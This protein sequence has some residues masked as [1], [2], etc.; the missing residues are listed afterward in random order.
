MSEVPK[1]KVPTPRRVSVSA[2]SE[3]PQRP[4]EPYQHE[5]PTP[6]RRDTFPIVMGGIIGALVI[7]LMVVVFLLSSNNGRTTTTQPGAGA[8]SAANSAAPTANTATL[9]PERIAMD[10]FKA[11]YDDP[12]K[13][14]I[15]VDV[16][17]KGTYDQGHIAGS[18]NI[19]MSDMGTRLAD[20]P[21]DKL[22]VAYCQ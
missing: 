7:G 11:L 5:V 20:M 1:R 16:R 3:Q 13:R 17:D 18:I 2:Q 21:K 22:V 6:S 15:I 9:E 19:P 10:A 12:A 4:Q 14:P 8:T